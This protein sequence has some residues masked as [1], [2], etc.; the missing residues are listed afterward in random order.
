MPIN[1]EEKVLKIFQKI[2]KI[3]KTVNNKASP[4]NIN[5]WDSLGHLRL[6]SELNKKLKIEISFEDTIKIR[7]LGDVIKTCIKYKKK[8]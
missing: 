7:N 1:V 8:K 6:I 2:F 4:E 5:T 3:N